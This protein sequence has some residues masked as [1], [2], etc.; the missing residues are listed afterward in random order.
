MCKMILVQGK[1]FNSWEALGL[2]YLA[3]YI[4]SQIKDINI[5]FYN[6]N[7][8]KIEDILNDCVNADF[9]FMSCTSPSFNYCVELAKSIK[10]INKNVRI[11]FGGYHVSSLKQDALVEGLDQIVIGEGEAASVEIINGNNDKI[12]YG[13]Q[14]NFSEL[15]WPD[16]DLIKNERH[17][18]VAF[19]DTGKN[20]TSFQ[21]HRTCPFKCKYCA[22]GHMKVLYQNM[23]IVFRSRDINDLINEIKYVSEK[24]KLDA[25]KFCD[26]TW[27]MDKN[28]VKD[29]CRAKINANI[30][31]PFFPNIHANIVDDEMFALLKEA[32]CYEI[33]LGIESGSPKILKQIGKGTSLE[34]I[35]NACDLASK[36]EVD[37]RGYF[38]LGMPDETED[39]LS[40]TEKFADELNIKEYG[41]TILCPYPGT[42]M[43]E[44]NKEE[45]RNIDWSI[46]DEY[47]N[48]F[49]HTKYVSNEKLREWQKKL[50]NKFK[51]KITWHNK[52]LMEQTK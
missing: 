22:D 46:T 10:Q 17:I 15:P 29:F 27:N 11:I 30:K 32:N 14:M 42:L 21:S 35:R 50:V 16:R 31:L 28:Y 6:G 34:T 7:F 51:N 36:N 12:V 40:L 47:I 52:V 37:V 23:K 38:I 1:Y 3:S 45:L 25:F 44:E 33:G 48:N 43:Y 2:G 8:D 26:A 13:R 24:Y 20:I 49:W 4:K 9:V 19:K 5:K 41:F 39:D 18:T